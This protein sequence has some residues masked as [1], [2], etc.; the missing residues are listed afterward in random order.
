MVD[1]TIAAIATAPGEAGIGVV[2][3]SGQKALGIAR[4]VFRPKRRGLWDEGSGWRV[5]YG[6]IVEGESGEVIDEGIAVVMP[7]PHSYTREDVVELQ[8]HGGTVVLR[9][10]L[11]SVLRCGA[12][13]AEPGEFTRRAFLNGRIDLAQAEAVVDLVRAQTEAASRLALDQLRGSLSI[14]IAEIKSKLVEMLVL[15]EGCID[16]PEDDVP[17][18]PRWDLWNRLEGALAGIERLLASAR[19][20]M[21]IREGSKAAI[22]GRPNVGKSS[23]LNALLGVERAIVTD[24]PGTTR[25]VVSEVVDIGGVPVRLA[26]TAGIR[27]TADLVEGI[28][29][30]RAVGEAA[31]ADLVLVVV[32]DSVGITGED[33][34][35]FGVVRN[36]LDAGRG[37]V[38]VNKID[39]GL[40]KVSDGE[41]A[42]WKGACPVVRV[43]CR[44]G[45]GLD[46]LKEEL[47]KLAV[48]GATVETGMVTRLRHKVALEEARAACLRA[49]EGLRRGDPLDVIAV[50]LREAAE[51]LGRVTGETVTDEVIAE[52]FSTFCVGK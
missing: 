28:G 44:T 21:V 40:G 19:A 29:V 16:F 32:D 8:C 34:E 46:E 47:R 10:V 15:I 39:L 50:E 36:L 11:E 2:R 25:D 14:R 49:G 33:R 42:Q 27:E 4:K 24:V 12:R 17:E 7:G 9:R 1:D 35:V 5:G 38:V 20:G 31:T 51:C 18:P 43:S 22:V 26:D 6:L 45:E 48:G 30:E 41:L 23:L 37:V 52:I 3:I 13:L